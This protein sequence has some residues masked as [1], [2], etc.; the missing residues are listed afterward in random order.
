MPWIFQ[1]VAAILASGVCQLSSASSEWRG[2]IIDE[3]FVTSKDR[4]EQA[5][6]AAGYGTG[7]QGFR[8]MI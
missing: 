6:G 1:N 5:I 2:P 7:I 8:S 4:S 3:S